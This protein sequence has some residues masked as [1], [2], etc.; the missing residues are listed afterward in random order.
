MNAEMAPVSVVIPCY[1]CQRTVER[2]VASVAAQTMVPA[3][4]ILIDDGSGDETPAMLQALIGRYRSGWIR[5]V[6]LAENLGAAS[7]RNAGWAVAGQPYIAFLDADDAW[8][9]KKIEIQYGFMQMNPDVVLC[10]H[11]HRL[12]KEDRLPDWDV[13]RG[14]VKRI[15]KWALLRSNKF[16]TPSVMLR[17]DIEHR[18]VEKQRYME[19]HMLWLNIVC[20]GARV[21]KLSEELAAIYKEAFG[22]TGLSSQVWLMERSDLGNYR[23]LY[24]G[25]YIGG[26][27]L[28]A[29][30]VY[31]TLKYVR[32]LIIYWGYLR[33]KK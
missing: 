33:W 5:L 9:P 28:T 7:A 24:L 23:R 25:G 15:R 19:D 22:V 21:V 12:L 29:L 18:F 16:V 14:P 10:G 32:R 4:I 8:H 17:R 11:G 26:A 30:V 2:A 31:S 13:L 3:E 27:Q 20:S 1:R 6:L